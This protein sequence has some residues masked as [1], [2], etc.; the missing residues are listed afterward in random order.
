VLAAVVLVLVGAILL[1]GESDERW[2]LASELVAG[3]VAGFVVAGAGLVWQRR[4]EHRVT[5]LASDRRNTVLRT[6]IEYVG[7]E[8][9][10]LGEELQLTGIDEQGHD[11]E[12]FDS[13]D[14]ALNAFRSHAG[15]ERMMR[16]VGRRRSRPGPQVQLIQRLALIVPRFYGRLERH[17]DTFLDFFMT[18]GDQRSIGAL[19]ELWDHQ[20]QMPDPPDTS[21]PSV[22]EVME[23]ATGNRTPRINQERTFLGGVVRMLLWYS[24]LLRAL[25]G[26]ES[27]I[28]GRRTSA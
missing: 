27:G 14:D 22:A 21:I 13:L 16:E 26:I 18:A 9:S 25:D 8:L 17:I 6:I 19:L 20:T 11:L 23:M 3:L 28:P 4:Y 2:N 10:P 7:V 15:V 24:E 5:A 12:L 1:F